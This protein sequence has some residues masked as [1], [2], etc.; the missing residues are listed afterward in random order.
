MVDY[1]TQLNRRYWPAPKQVTFYKAPYQRIIE[2]MRAW[3]VR[4]SRPYAIETFEGTLEEALKRLVPLNSWPHLICD[5]P[6][7]WC[8]LLMG[9]GDTSSAAG[10][11]AKTLKVKTLWI[12]EVEDTFDPK[13]KRGQ[14]GATQLEIYDGANMKTLGDCLR[15]ISSIRGE[16]DRWEFDTEGDVQPF[17]DVS[18]YT[19]KP[20]RKRF[21]RELLERYCRA[22]GID[23]FN[24]E[25]YGP[26]FTILRWQ[27]PLRPEWGYED[28][29]FLLKRA[30]LTF[31]D[32]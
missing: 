31:P 11:L 21:D 4:N 32:D 19:V 15:R 13:T 29:E 25:F 12:S 7:K 2:G 26:Q 9:L 27:Y 8:P 20:V 18:R 24:P 17:E 16:S 3:A 23:P 6:T 28:Y 1:W 22:M 10:Y 5:S 30:G 14:P